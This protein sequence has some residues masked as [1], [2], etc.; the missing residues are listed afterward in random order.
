MQCN[1]C[2]CFL[3][4]FWKN[5]PLFSVSN[6][7]NDWMR[8]LQQQQQQ[9]IANNND[10]STNL[11]FNGGVNFGD[12]ANNGQNIDLAQLSQL[13]QQSQNYDANTM[14][15]NALQQQVSQNRQ[16]GQQPQPQQVDATASNSNNTGNLMFG[17]MGAENI[18]AAL[19]AA[20][21]SNNNN[22]NPVNP[23]GYPQQLFSQQQQQ[24]EPKNELD[25]SQQQGVQDSQQLQ[26]EQQQLQELQLQ[27]QVLQQQQQQLLQQMSQFQ[28]QHSNSSPNQIT[29]NAFAGLQQLQEFSSLNNSFAKFNP[30]ATNQEAADITTITTNQ[31]VN[32]IDGLDGSA[33]GHN[34]D[35]SSMNDGT[36]LLQQQLAMLQQQVQSFQQQPDF[37]MPS[38]E[39]M[40]I[41]LDKGQSLQQN[42]PPPQTQQQLD[43]QTILQQQQFLLQSQFL[44]NQFE[45]MQQQQQQQLL[46]N[47]K[48]NINNNTTIND[49][50]PAWIF[51]QNMNINSVALNTAALAMTGTLSGAAKE[52]NDNPSQDAMMFASPAA[53][54]ASQLNALQGIGMIP[55]LQQYQQQQQQQLQQQQNN[56]VQQ[57]DNFVVSTQ[58]QS[59]LSSIG[60]IVAL[61]QVASVPLRV[62][63]DK[64]SNEK[65]TKNGQDGPSVPK[66]KKAKSFPEKLMDALI[67]YA[68][69]DAIAWLPDGKSFVIVNPDLFCSKILSQAFKEAKYASFVRKL[70][71]WGFVRLT[72]GTGTDCFHHPLFQRNR[73]DLVGKLN[74]VPRGEKDHKDHAY[75]IK[76]ASKPPS[77][78]GV[79]KFIR[80]KVVASAASSGETSKD[81]H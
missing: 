5:N 32:A 76:M 11:N 59:G 33:N 45:Q 34:Q 52:M 12:A 41:E 61:P 55:N 73:K 66:K 68:D 35:G 51:G 43:P 38:Q 42:H 60:S 17:M 50:I 62:T 79:E 71:R 1:T 58:N 39:E 2:V 65:A 57:N 27:Q 72:S 67:D 25:G 46:S 22:N 77:L 16:F 36:Q 74:C 70:H 21:S 56:L 13:S 28:V 20:S 6:I 80:A 44:Q 37:R 18:L 64:K 30:Q 4:F 81:W 23:Q 48:Q 31:N 19:A 40:A 3:S 54:T 24:P 26:H 69:E 29:P 8:Q 49:G 9:L 47:D 75:P 63:H 15:M 10:T 53:A 7:G 14:L 78:A